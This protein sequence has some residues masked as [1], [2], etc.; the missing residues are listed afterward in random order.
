MKVAP[1]LCGQASGCPEQHALSPEG[2]G[3]APWGLVLLFLLSCCDCGELVLDP[4]A[5]HEEAEDGAVQVL[6]EGGAAEV[7][8]L[9]RVD[10]QGGQ[11]TQPRGRCPAPTA[12]VARLLAP[13]AE[14][15]LRASGK[16][17]DNT[18]CLVDCAS[19]SACVNSQHGSRLGDHGGSSQACRGQHS[20]R[21][22]RNS[23]SATPVS[24]GSSRLAVCRAQGL[25]RTSAS[26]GV[27]W[28]RSSSSN[29]T[30]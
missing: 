21:T 23:D 1:R 4:E 10:L 3:G 9:I 22:G 13:T 18:L 29:L 19:G 14:G 27:Q 26:R 11:R 20:H 16:K 5:F 17:S 25:S 8:A 6:L 7:V 15:V 30:H 28:R 2:P 12:R 24:A